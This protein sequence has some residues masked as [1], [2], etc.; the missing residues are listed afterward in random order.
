MCFNVLIEFGYISV[1]LVS[2]K[3][4]NLRK[5]SED[6]DGGCVYMHVDGCAKAKHHIKE[7]NSTSETET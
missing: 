3:E 5:G 2:C 1:F 4:W 6:G 7:E